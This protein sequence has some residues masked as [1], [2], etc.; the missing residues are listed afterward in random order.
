MTSSADSAAPGPLTPR[1]WAAG[2][3]VAIVSVF[4][5]L[6][7]THAAGVPFRDPNH[8]V[9]RRL[10]QVGCLIALLVAL[11]IVIRAGRRSWRPGP[12]LAAMR[13]VRRDRWTWQRAA[14]VAIALVSF[15]V[16]Y[17]AYRNLKSMVPLLRPGD[18]FDRE[19]A[20]FERGYFAG[21]APAELLHST[22]GTTTA[23]EVLSSVYMAFIFLVP[24]SLALALVFSP[25]TQGGVFYAVALSINWALGA[26]SYLVLPAL[27]PIYAAPAGFADLPAT[28]ASH[29]QGVLLSQR[30]EFLSD[31]AAANAH[32]SIAAF[33]SLHTSIVFTAAVAAHMLGLGRW[34]RFATWALFGLTAIATIYFGWHYVVDDV[35]GLV[36]GLAALALAR[37]LTGFEPRAVRWLRLPNRA[38][39]PVRVAAARFGRQDHAQS[40]L[41]GKLGGDDKPL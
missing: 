25:S 39:L 35:A 31:P 36:I 34:L 27:G 38:G 26:A 12:W 1:G 33:G 30:L 16:T 40:R 29:L 22:L 2:P 8:M 20:D 14:A 32:Q 17:L 6:L 5:A 13:A 37:S 3:A 11:D 7:G 23:A 28:E 24:V 18:L 4:M 19:L 21:T 41:T 10:L 15:Y 9:A